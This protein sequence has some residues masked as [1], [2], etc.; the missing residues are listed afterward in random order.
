[1]RTISGV[2]ASATEE[3][4]D[5]AALAQTQPAPA[6]AERPGVLPAR[7][8]PSGHRRPVELRAGPLRP[9]QHRRAGRAAVRPQEARAPAVRAALVAAALGAALGALERRALG[10]AVL[11][12]APGG[13]RVLRQRREL[14]APAVR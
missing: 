13:R 8:A 9:E 11:D 6:P 7:S 14:Q 12:G 5:L 10:H 4:L 3:V 2:M 1:M